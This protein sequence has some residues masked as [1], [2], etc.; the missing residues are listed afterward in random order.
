MSGLFKWNR[1]LPICTFFFI[2]FLFVVRVTVD[3]N[4]LFTVFTLLFKGVY[5]CISKQFCS[6]R[7][8]VMQP[9]VCKLRLKE[10]AHL[11]SHCDD[12]DSAATC[13]VIT[14][15]ALQL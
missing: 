14:S 15:L 10:M 5:L 13:K 1:I 12:K 8:K 2:I 7:A 9:F 4:E 11:A 3:K 6:H